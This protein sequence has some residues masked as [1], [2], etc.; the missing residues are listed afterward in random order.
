MRR[1]KKEKTL[2]EKIV[3]FMTDAGAFAC[4]RQNDIDFFQSKLKS[5]NIKD[6]VTTADFA[7]SRMFREFVAKEFGNLDYIIVDEEFVHKLGPDP[8]AEI[9]KHK[10][11][12]VIDPIDGTL[13]YSNKYPFW[14]ICVGV[15]KDGEPF[16]G[17][18]FAPA[19]NLMVYAD[20]D[21]AYT[22]E[23]GETKELRP[24]PDNV[25]SAPIFSLSRNNKVFLKEPFDYAAI[26]PISGQPAV[27]NMIWV[28]LGMSRGYCFGAYIWDISGMLPVF[29]RLGIQ[30][31]GVT[32]GRIF[33]PFDSNT[34]RSD[35]LRVSHLYV[36]SRPKYY[37]YLKD[38]LE[39]KGY[40][41]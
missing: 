11:A 14:G 6:V 35:A 28:A 16:V 32:D 18:A 19:L 22:V 1:Y 8:I 7:V 12:F 41:K 40:Y 21:K 37:D 38:L 27:I 24:L 30:I 10:Y 17:G 20:E 9:K 26:L 23:N 31:R 4:A 36:I 2:I 13:A 34:Y 5:E 25:E 3:K 39:I 33:T 29:L 15:F